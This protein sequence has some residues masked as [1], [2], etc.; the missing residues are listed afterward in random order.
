VHYS[1]LISSLFFYF[2]TAMSCDEAV[3]QCGTWI[4]LSAQPHNHL[5]TATVSPHSTNAMDGLSDLS[6]DPSTS[7]AD[8]HTNDDLVVS[9]T[10]P[11]STTAVS[12][13]NVSTYSM[14]TQVSDAS[15]D[16]S[17]DQGSMPS[18][19]IDGISPRRAANVDASH[20][21]GLMTL[22]S[23]GPPLTATNLMVHE[24]TTSALSS[25]NSSVVLWLNSGMGEHQTDADDWSQLMV[26][27]PLA[28]AI[29]G[30]II[31]DSHTS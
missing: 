2:Y 18:D 15:T 4:T 5:H 11:V 14:E 12:G 29:E 27:D 3:A 13:D 22:I 31:V 25:S 28:A 21:E 17:V 16:L 8:D 24:R 26:S 19:E 6:R 1:Q 10:S 23:P 20:H 7:S 9:L 30:A